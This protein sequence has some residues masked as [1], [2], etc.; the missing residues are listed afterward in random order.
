MLITAI[1]P[2]KMRRHRASDLSF[3]A[4]RRHASNPRNY[5][6]WYTYATGYHPA[7]NAQINATLKAKGTITEA[8][9]SRL[10]A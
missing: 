10:R 8:D 1:P 9:T 2:W 4:Q 3:P 6:I 5:E 7:L